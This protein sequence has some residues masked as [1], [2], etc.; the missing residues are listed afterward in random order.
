MSSGPVFIQLDLFGDHVRIVPK[1]K[2][3]RQ[4]KIKT[5][6]VQLDFFGDHVVFECEAPKKMK[7]KKRGDHVEHKIYPLFS[8]SSRCK[9]FEASEDREREGA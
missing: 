8:D 4:R 7:K 3:K 6:V 9:L 1:I 5:N 2:R